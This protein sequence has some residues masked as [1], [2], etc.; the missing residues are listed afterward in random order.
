MKKVSIKQ[1]SQ[2]VLLL[3]RLEK[4]SGNWKAVSMGGEWS[5]EKE[6]ESEDFYLFVCFLSR[7][8]DLCGA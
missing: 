4:W 2:G 1:L 5:V 6:E 3:R 8:P 7:I